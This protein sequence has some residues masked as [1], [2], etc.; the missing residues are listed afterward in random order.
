MNTLP[1]ILAA[2]DLSAP[3]RHAVERAAMVSKQTCAALE[4]L[5]VAN[6]APLE[7][8]RQLMLESSDDLQ[9]HVE[10]TARDKLR[11]L[12]AMLQQRYGVVASARVVL[13][14]LLKEMAREVDAVQPGLMVC[15][16]KGENMLQHLILGSTAERLLS[17]APCPVLVVKQI[18]RDNYQTLLVPVDFSRFSLRAI[19]HART[20]APDA[21]IILLHAF[22]VPF[23]GQLRYAS[24]DKKVI[25]CYRVV[26]H[27]EAMLRL[28]ALSDEAGLSSDNSRLLVLQG[29]PSLRIIEQE[30]DLDCDLIVLGRHGQNM[31]DTFFLGSVTKHV[32][33]ESQCDVLVA[34]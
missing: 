1:L 16:A 33:A 22:E 2:T 5:H 24:V 18:P 19:K 14:S 26:G 32:L 28:R 4:L 34:V 17:V 10:D 12:A 27:K 8:L 11:E 9:R 29:H 15:G 3:A 23:E 13:G 30:Q 6:L 31:L 7:R 20:V 21:N 25:D